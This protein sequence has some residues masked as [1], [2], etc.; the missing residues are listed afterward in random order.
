MNC[1]HDAVVCVRARTYVRIA[2]ASLSRAVCGW[3]V[4]WLILHS[5][6]G[7]KLQTHR[8]GSAAGETFK[9]LAEDADR[10]IDSG[11]RYQIPRRRCATIE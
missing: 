10:P 3:L 1:A 11:E 8:W 9:R 2:F 4:G 6:G 7:L 5:R